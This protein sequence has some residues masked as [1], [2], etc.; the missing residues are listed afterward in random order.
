[1]TGSRFI[2][3]LFENHEPFIKKK[4]RSYLAKAD[5]S[6]KTVKMVKSVKTPFFPPTTLHLLTCPFHAAQSKRRDSFD[7]CAFCFIHFYPIPFSH[8]LINSLLSHHVFQ[9]S[10][11]ILY[12]GVIFVANKWRLS[13]HCLV[14]SWRNNA[15]LQHFWPWFVLVWFRE[16][17]TQS[18][19]EEA[20]PEPCDSLL[21]EHK[22]RCRTA[23][24]AAW[25]LMP[26]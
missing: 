26:D 25:L 4:Q 11:V 18:K 2:L 20:Q 8:V 3:S 14:I 19:R 15:R 1:M 10:A 24:Y 17:K 16:R 13:M 22:L 6:V 7:E 21:R 12:L 9:M 23:E 5:Q